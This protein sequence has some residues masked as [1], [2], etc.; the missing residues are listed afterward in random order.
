MASPCP[1]WVTSGGLGPTLRRQVDPGQRTPP[2]AEVASGSGHFEPP[3][4]EAVAAERASIAD[5]GEAM[6]PPTVRP[7]PSRRQVL[8]NDRTPRVTGAAPAPGQVQAAVIYSVTM[9]TTL[10]GTMNTDLMVRFSTCFATD[11]NANAC[12]RIA[13]SDSFRAACMMPRSLPLT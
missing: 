6:R 10:C 8:P 13:A 4:F 5:A 2:A 12:A 9:F 7:G 1:L 11:G 3:R